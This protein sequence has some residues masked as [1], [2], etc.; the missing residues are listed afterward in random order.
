MSVH[1][2]SLK[3]NGKVVKMKNFRPQSAFR[4]LPEIELPSFIYSVLVFFKVLWIAA[5]ISP[6][7][8]EANFCPSAGR[9]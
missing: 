6:L 5:I 8:D 4:N 1:K 2:D 3:L 7:T 9:E